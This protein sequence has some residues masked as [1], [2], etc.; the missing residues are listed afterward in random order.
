MQDLARE[1]RVALIVPIYEVEQEGVCYNTAAVIHNDGS[2]LGKYRKTHI[3]T[4]L[5]LLGEILFPPRQPRLSRLRP[6]LRQ[7]R[8]LHLLRPP[9]PRGRARPGTERRRDRLQPVGHRAG[10]SE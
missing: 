1:L 8:R 4:W 10:L 9:F 5:P 6:R 3:P 2:F 7:D